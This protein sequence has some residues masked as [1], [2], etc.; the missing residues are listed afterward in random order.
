MKMHHLITYPGMQ[1]KTMRNYFMTSTRSVSKDIKKW[2]YLFTTHEFGYFLVK[3]S[4]SRSW[5]YAYL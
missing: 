4:T 1:I 3:K 5:I 2:E